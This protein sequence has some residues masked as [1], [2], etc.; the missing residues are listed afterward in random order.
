M[1]FTFT[2]V[3]AKRDLKW[4]RLL[5]G[6]QDQASARILRAHHCSDTEDS[7]KQCRLGGKAWES[8][9]SRR[10]GGLVTERL[11]K[12]SERE[13]GHLRQD[14]RRPSLRTPRCPH[15]GIWQRKMSSGL[16]KEHSK[17]GRLFLESEFMGVENKS[18]RGER[19][20]HQGE[21][22]QRYLC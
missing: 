7:R 9:V 22:L 18:L 14:Q 12:R 11:R 15:S 19:R 20:E 2:R 17:A 13:K 3:R 8:A 16:G 5:G 1:S 10:H 21:N 4:A 6:P